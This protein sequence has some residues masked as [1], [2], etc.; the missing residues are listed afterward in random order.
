MGTLYQPTHLLILVL[1]AGL[2]GIVPVIFYILTL[3]KAL[4]K[5]APQSR[6]ID[7]GM[8]W[9]SIV[10]LV[11]MVWNF[12]LV[13]G[14]ANTLS[15]EF[16]LRGA[17]VQGEKPGQSI[18]MAMCICAVCS[19]IPILGVLASLASLALWIVYWVKIAEFSQKLD[20]VQPVA[21]IA[22]L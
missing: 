15:N 22:A 17:P 2:I 1:L 11:S 21:Q 7:P 18:G 8:C 12:F 13:L 10:P 3:Q 19:V 14:V 4:H 16:A 20:V 9:L 5:C 6:T